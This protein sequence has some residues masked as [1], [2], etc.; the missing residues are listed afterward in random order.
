MKERVK[1]KNIKKTKFFKRSIS[2]LMA[3][4][5]TFNVT[6]FDVFNINSP[7]K[8]FNTELEDSLAVTASAAE[9]TYT[10]S[11]PDMTRFANNTAFPNN[12]TGKSD[13]LDFCYFYQTDDDFA[14]DYVNATV[15]V[16]FITF[17]AEF[18]GLGNET[19]KFRGDFRIQ[20]SG[21]ENVNIPRA[22]FTH[23]YDSAKITNASGTSMALKIVKTSDQSSPLIADYVY[24]DESEGLFP[25]LGM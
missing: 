2:V 8:V 7:S 5:L 15:S 16:N 21:E 9:L 24:H 4:S 23:V 13:F 1:G 20:D 11:N 25:H 19:V 10:P 18:M 6:P 17:P 3:L 14:A 22:I 12:D